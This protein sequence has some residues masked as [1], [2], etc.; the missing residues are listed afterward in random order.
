MRTIRSI[1]NKNVICINLDTPFS[2]ACRIFKEFSFHHLPVIA[3]DKTLIGIF[4]TTD[5]ITS[6]NRL[7]NRESITAIQT[8][9]DMLT[10]EEC[11]TST[12]LKTMDVNDDFDELIKL[13]QQTDINS[14]PIVESNRIVGIV[15]STDIMKLLI[16]DISSR[17][18]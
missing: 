15:T 9:D 16:E 6:I 12:Q 17:T 10:I 14:I 3:D 7:S 4:S 11:M 5:A 18:A 13:Y 8:L 1:M 2:E